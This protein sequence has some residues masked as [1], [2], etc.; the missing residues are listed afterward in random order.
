MSAN[1]RDPIERMKAIEI[2]MAEDAN[3][4]S[5]EQIVA[6]MKEDGIDPNAKAQELRASA[7]S[8]VRAAK[9]RKLEAARAR[10]EGVEQGFKTPAKRPSI[11]EIKRRFQEILRGGSANGLAIAF[12]EGQQQSDADWESLWDDLVDLGLANPDEPDS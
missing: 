4:L 2:A 3:A 6:E 9:R 1:E 12:R 7:L 5:D 11:A 8:I 10:L